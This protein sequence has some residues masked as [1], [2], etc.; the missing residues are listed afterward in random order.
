VTIPRWLPPGGIALAAGLF[1]WLNRGER[2][3]VSIGITTFYGAPLTVVVFLAFLAGMLAMLALSLRHDLRMR[4]ELSARGLLGGPP[5][6]GTSAWPAAAAS[7]APYHPG[8]GD[9]TVAF[10]V[11]DDTAGFQGDGGVERPGYGADGAQVHD[12]AVAH[13]QQSDPPLN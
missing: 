3:V 6:P 12:P 8:P 9:E 1:T 10:P 2:A 7:L 13:R 11:D 5:V 4:E